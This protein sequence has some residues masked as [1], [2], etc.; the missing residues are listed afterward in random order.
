MN[1]FWRKE[2]IP[3]VCF[4]LTI[5]DWLLDILSDVVCQTITWVSQE[6]SLGAYVAIANECMVIEIKRFKVRLHGLNI[7][8]HSG[9]IVEYPQNPSQT[10][11]Y[12]KGNPACA[13]QSEASQLILFK[14]ISREST[15]WLRLTTH[16]NVI[17]AVERRTFQGSEKVQ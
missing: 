13:Q 1:F 2:W 3:S 11:S 7:N 4:Y 15:D 12:P 9:T 6:L 17:D 16:I 5:F 14:N 8:N 10:L